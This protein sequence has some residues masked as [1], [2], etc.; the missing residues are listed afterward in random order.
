MKRK[1][2]LFTNVAQDAVISAYDVQTTIYEIPS[3]FE[4]QGLDEIVVKKLGITCPK[5]DL[6]AWQKVVDTYVN[7]KKAIRIGIVGKYIELHDSYKSIF[8][9]LI[10]G[11]IANKV[12]VKLI[13]IDSEKIEKEENVSNC[14]QDVD[15]ILVPGGFGQR[16]IEGMVEAVRFARLQKVPCFGI[17]LGMQ[18]MVIEYARSFLGYQ[19]A[20]STEFVPQSKHS[21]ICLL[22]EQIDIKAYGGTMRLGRSE[23]KLRKNTL[24]HKIYGKEIIEERHRHRYEVSNIF[25]NELESKGLIISGTTIDDSLVESIE[26]QDH[27]WGIGVQFHPEFT[28]KPISPQ[29]L[30]KS[31]I[32]ASIDYAKK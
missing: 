18:V 28:S 19:D 32:A 26:W 13:K 12:K 1:I 29:L 7:A 2:S 4:K 24:I 22:E 20:N 15:G 10:H 8:E 30:F 17:C 14:F 25:K 11:G 31:F 23:T 21:V 9:A 5:S 6:R 3:T 27:P 16:G